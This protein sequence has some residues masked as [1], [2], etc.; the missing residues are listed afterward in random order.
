MCLLLPC[1]RAAQEEPLEW[2]T[3]RGCNVFRV[4]AGHFFS[5]RTIIFISSI[6][7]PCSFFLLLW[8]LLLFCSIIFCSAGGVGGLRGSEIRMSDTG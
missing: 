4:T 2:T 1:S 8:L 5:Y 3:S 7:W 6:N